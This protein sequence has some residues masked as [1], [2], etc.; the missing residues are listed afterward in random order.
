M[1]I[2]VVAHSHPVVRVGGGEVAAYREWEELVRRAIPAVF[3]G[4]TDDPHA[5][6]LFRGGQRVVRHGPSDYVVRAMAYDGFGHDLRTIL[7][8]DALLD[9][10]A[11]LPVDTFHFHHFW[12]IGVG[13]LRRLM[14][15]RPDA[16]FALTLHEYQAICAADGQLLRTRS[17]SPCQK[18][19]PVDCALC[20]PAHTPFDF[21]HRRQKLS[22]L[23]ASFDLVLAPSAFLRDRFLDWGLAPDRIVVL[24]NGLAFPPFVGEPSPPEARASRFA[25]FGRPTPTKGLSV[26]VEAAA[27]LA[28]T[29]EK[30]L[31]IDVY[32]AT[33]AEFAALHPGTAVPDSVAFRGPYQPADATS[34]MRRFGWIVLPSIWW[35]NSPVVIQEAR[36]AGVPMIAS[37]FGGILE[38]TAGWSLHFNPGDAIDLARVMERVAGDGAALAAQTAAITPPADTAAFVDALLALLADAKTRRRG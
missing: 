1:T 7:D 23:V 3:V 14:A 8:E 10:L 31:A 20:L 11:A 2:A 28:R 38:K 22:A 32:G 25:F 30:R 16:T 21:V 27:H 19:S 9:L 6:V 5:E 35:E 33:A 37:G 18:A 24:E 15:A 29:S 12:N 34:I 4:L 26:L 17:Q 13:T 36:A